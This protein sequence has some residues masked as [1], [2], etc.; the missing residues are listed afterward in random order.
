V[1]PERRG[2]RRGA[3]R[4]K[5]PPGAKKY[6]LVA[7]LPV[8]DALARMEGAP[9]RQYG[10]HEE[11]LR[12]QGCAAAGY[13]LLATDGGFAPYCCLHLWGSWRLIT[14]FEARRVILV[15]LG[16]HDGGQFYRRLAEELGTR[17]VGQRRAQKPACCGPEGWPTLGVG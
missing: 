16:R 13:R 1:T 12:A 2:S 6:E 11:A 17:A 3:P 5:P 4:S 7:T 9:R 8:I 15:A 10:R 14:T